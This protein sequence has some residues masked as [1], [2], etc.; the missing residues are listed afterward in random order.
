MSRSQ[1]IPACASTSLVITASTAKPRSTRSWPVRQPAKWL[2]KSVCNRPVRWSTVAGACKGPPGSGTLFSAK[3][4]APNAVSGRCSMTAPP[5]TRATT[6]SPTQTCNS[7]L[8]YRWLV[9]RAKAAPNRLRSS[10]PGCASA[11]KTT[12]KFWC[13]LGSTIAQKALPGIKPMRRDGV[14]FMGGQLCGMVAAESLGEL[15]LIA[16]CN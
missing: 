2:C 1:K 11:S 4:R 9:W 15:L 14:V 5:H 6:L 8:L 13:P 3:K 12:R 7:S 10:A 16:K